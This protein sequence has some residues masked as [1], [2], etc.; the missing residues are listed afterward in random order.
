LPVLL[1]ASLQNNEKGRGSNAPALLLLTRPCYPNPM[2]AD[3]RYRKITAEE[4]LAIDFGTDRRFELVDGVIQMMGGGSEP[5][6]WVQGN[7]FAWLRHA[8]KGSKC[9]PYGPDMGIRVSDTDVRYPDISIHCGERPDPDDRVLALTEPTI[10]IEVVSPTTTMIDQGTKLEEYKELASV[11]L[12][13]FIDPINELVRTV[14]RTSA[15]GWI[16]TMFGARDLDLPSIG[17]TIPHAE[18]FSPD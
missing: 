3:P 9:R 18:I 2:R 5:H 6:A 14:K 12:I 16:D 11:D 1:P 13:A 7:L 15:F 8:L 17:L 10:V 4:F